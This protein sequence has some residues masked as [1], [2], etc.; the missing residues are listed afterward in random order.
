MG[1]QSIDRW[2]ESNQSYGFQQYTVHHSIASQF[3]LGDYPIER[4][5]TSVIIQFLGARGVLRI[6]CDQR[7]ELKYAQIS[8]PEGVR[9]SR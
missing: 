4:G 2:H 7:F 6:P 5:H 9:V 8:S 3:I 1:A